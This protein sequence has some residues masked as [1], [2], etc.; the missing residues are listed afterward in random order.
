M[1]PEVRQSLSMMKYVINHKKVRGS[2]QILADTIFDKHICFIRDKTKKPSE[3]LFVLWTDIKSSQLDENAR[4]V[5]C[6]DP[7]G[8]KVR[9]PF[10]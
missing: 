8:K 5:E 10:D 2:L 9:I 1:E 3:Y 7:E 6:E 4:S